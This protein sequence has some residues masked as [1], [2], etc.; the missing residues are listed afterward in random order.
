MPMDASEIE[1][2]IKLRIPDAQVTIVGNA[3][4]FDYTSTQ[5]VYYDDGFAPAA[6][7]LQ[8]LLGVGQIIKSSTASDSEDVTVIIGVDLVS[9][10][11]LKITRTNGG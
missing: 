8:Q 6:T 10:Q 5:I 9:K 4:R 2:L 1:R 11:G 7:A 3:D